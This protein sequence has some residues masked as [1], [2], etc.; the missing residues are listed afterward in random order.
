M[1]LCGGV[2]GRLYKQDTPAV[3]K[4]V[5]EGRNGGKL[6]PLITVHC[7]LNSEMS[8]DKTTNTMILVA[9]GCRTEAN[10]SRGR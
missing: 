10:L 3:Q 4:E 7:N 9:T 5:R 6:P 8:V 1:V 2:G